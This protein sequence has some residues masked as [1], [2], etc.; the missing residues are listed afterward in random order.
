MNAVSHL[1]SSLVLNLPNQ[2]SGSGRI[3]SNLIRP[4]YS[5]A[6]IIEGFWG[7]TRWSTCCPK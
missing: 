4:L 2:F 7:C 3:F 6:I 5:L 1:G